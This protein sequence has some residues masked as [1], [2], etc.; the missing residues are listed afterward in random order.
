MEPE[1]PEGVPLLLFNCS[2]EGL[3][4]NG[5]PVVRLVIVIFILHVII[6]LAYVLRK[7]EKDGTFQISDYRAY[8]LYGFGLFLVSA[9][10]LILSPEGIV[11]VLG[12]AFLAF[13]L[14]LIGIGL[15]EK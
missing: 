1:I 8:L 12:L 15:Q 5:S 7:K 6:I 13:G 4:M 10:F 11:L 3:K 2:E 9:C 14:G